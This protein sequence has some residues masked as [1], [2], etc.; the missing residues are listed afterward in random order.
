MRTKWLSLWAVLRFIRSRSSGWSPKLLLLA[1]ILYV[2]LP[3]DVIP[4][5][6]VLVGWLDDLGV[7]ALCLSLIGRAFRRS[8][9]ANS[10]TTTLPRDPVLTNSAAT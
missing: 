5:V 7:V 9:T 3:V 1:A 8:Q 2:V 10:Q 4:D 6:F